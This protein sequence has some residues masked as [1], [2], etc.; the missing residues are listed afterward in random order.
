MTT[1]EAFEIPVD[2]TSQHEV[3]ESTETNVNTLSKKIAD[4]TDNEYNKIV[5]DLMNGVVYANYDLKKFNNGSF[6]LVYKKKPTTRQKAVERTQNKSKNADEKVVYL[7][8]NQLM[9]E[10]LID[11]EVK[12]AK[13]EMKNKKR[14]NQINEIMDSYYVDE[15]EIETNIP[16]KQEKPVS[17]E[18]AP[19][20][21]TPRA[22]NWRSRLKPK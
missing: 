6:R 22:T 7:T 12:C 13:L 3:C 15:E 5:N 10:R 14:K 20:C 19:Q 4:L 8:D 18:I 17:E 21:K 16:E 9:L 1:D 2:S 11:L